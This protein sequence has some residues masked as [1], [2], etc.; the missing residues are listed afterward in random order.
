ME[1]Y[2]KLND[3]CT[4]ITVNE[5]MKEIDMKLD[6][7]KNHNI[8]MKVN[9]NGY[10]FASIKEDIKIIIE[11][12]N[13]MNQKNKFDYIV[14]VM[15]KSNKFNKGVKNFMTIYDEIK[16]DTIPKNSKLFYHEYKEFIDLNN[17]YDI[18]G[19]DT[20]DWYNLLEC[21]NVI[22]KFSII[23]QDEYNKYLDQDS[24]LPTNPIEYYKLQ[25]INT[26]NDLLCTFYNILI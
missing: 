23:N 4:N 25:N 6:D 14:S 18:L 11:N 16:N 21:K 2:K 7:N 17:W 20:E 15:K 9:I 8:K 24:R 10:D 1:T 12:D 19:I 22:A 3:I 26:Y 5:E 13:K